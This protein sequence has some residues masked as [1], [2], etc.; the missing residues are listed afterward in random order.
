MSQRYAELARGGIVKFLLRNARPRYKRDRLANYTRSTCA[1]EPRG[2]YGSMKGLGDE[3]VGGQETSGAQSGAE[4][5]G[6]RGARRRF[7]GC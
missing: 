5:A 1:S 4:S 2:T 3:V 6:G 7:R